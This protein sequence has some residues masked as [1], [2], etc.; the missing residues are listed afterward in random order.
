MAG[1]EEV[2]QETKETEEWEEGEEE[3]VDGECRGSRPSRSDTA[4]LTVAEAAALAEGGS[5][6]VITVV[7][8]VLGTG[9]VEPCVRVCV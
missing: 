5:V 2:E 3:E 1:A 8:G 9:M 6:P 4:V 7:E